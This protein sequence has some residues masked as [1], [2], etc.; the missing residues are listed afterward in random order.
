MNYQVSRI[1]ETK[2][3][4]EP[5][6]AIIPSPEPVRF[7]GKPDQELVMD[8]YIKLPVMDE[9]FF[10][11]IVGAYLKKKKTGYEITVSN[12]VDNRIYELPPVIM[13]DGIIINDASII[14]N[15][16][17]DFVEKID[18]IRERY[19]VGNYIFYGIVNVITRKGDF[20]GFP[21]SQNAIRVPYRVI[22]PVWSFAS[23]D[24]SL[25]SVKNN[26][27]PDFRNTLYWNPAVNPGTDGKAKVQF[28]TS[29]VKSD[30]VITVQGITS[31]GRPVTVRKT[32]SVK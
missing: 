12:P 3:V 32:I 15:L 2:A 27:I 7:Y 29:D 26:R 30:Y 4:G 18:L 19:F 16:D 25:P 23:P 31:E 10:E 24:Y 1:Y 11:L 13:V 9:V 17:P 21:L 20:D 14:G 5:M 28:W 8:D 6:H 22:E